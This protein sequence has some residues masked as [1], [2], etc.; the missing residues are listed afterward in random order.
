MRI[1]ERIKHLFF[2]FFGVFGENLGENRERERERER[3]RA[4]KN[5]L[6]A[7]NSLFFFLILQDLGVL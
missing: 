1:Q 6:N 5:A 7:Q 3:E 2:L 4:L